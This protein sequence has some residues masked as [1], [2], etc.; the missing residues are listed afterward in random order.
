MK[1]LTK[2]LLAGAL[3]TVPFYGAYAANNSPMQGL[4]LGVHI[5]VVDIGLDEADLEKIGI[6]SWSP[7]PI[8]L[9][10]S[11]G[12]AIALTPQ[13]DIVPELQL[14]F[15]I[16]KDSTNR[17]IPPYG[18]IKYEMASK[19]RFALG[20]KLRYQVIDDLYLYVTPQFYKQ[21]IEVSVSFPGYSASQTG[22]NDG[23][24]LGVGGSYGL[25]DHILLDMRFDFDED[26]KEMR[27]GMIY[28]F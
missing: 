26:A 15:G 20:G 4:E 6:D 22:D 5:G 3:L 10:L 24:A 19:S 17:N 14:G 23:V 1:H 7:K 8:E 28:R 25:T 2:T 16:K 9:T 21:K 18:S 12:Y 11:A 13:F 27:A